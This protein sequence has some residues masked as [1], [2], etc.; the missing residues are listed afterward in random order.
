[1]RSNTAGRRAARA[2]VGGACTG[3]DTTSARVTGFLLSRTDGL[4]ES[5]RSPELPRSARRSSR[6]DDRLA[7]RSSPTR[8]MRSSHLLHGADDRNYGRRRAALRVRR[9]HA[10]GHGRRAADWTDWL[11][12]TGSSACGHRHA[13]ARAALRE[14]GA[15]GAIVVAGRATSVEVLVR[16]AVDGGPRAGRSRPA[17]RL[18]IGH[19]DIAVVD[20]GCKRS[21]L[22]A[23]GPG[24]AVTV[25]P[26][27]V[28][29]DR[30]RRAHDGVVLSNGPGDPEPLRD[31][32]GR[33]PLLGRVPVLGICL[34]HQLLALAP[35]RTFKLRS[36]TAARTTRSSSRDEPRAA[37]DEPEPRLRGRGRR[38]EVRT[39]RSTTARSRARLPSVA[40]ARCSSTRRPGRARTT[41]GRCSSVGGGSLIA[42]SGLTSARSAWSAR[43]RS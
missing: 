41:P 36:A 24:A 11:R 32:S 2:A 6:R 29:A 34:G 4:P 28:D 10:R 8:A 30:A 33:R 9:R 16:P 22:R 17:T 31:G 19:R 42:R 20:Y 25:Y 21:I 15:M 37:R 35:A 1:M 3:G 12:A 5:C 39:S 40:R 26:H 18:R 38:P 43:A 27:D 14:G 23:R 7:R 13:L